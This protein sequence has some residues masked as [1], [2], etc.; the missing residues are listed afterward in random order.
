MKM[1]ATR[2]RQAG[3]TREAW[4]IGVSVLWR[5]ALLGTVLFLSLTDDPD[6][7]LKHN[8]ISYIVAMV[9]CYYD[10]AF[11]RRRWLLAWF[12]GVLLHLAGVGFGNLLALVFGNPVI[13]A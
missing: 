12:E 10:G 9:W 5:G 2:L 6:R 11:S 1:L 3:L 13:P 7:N 4:L 8:L